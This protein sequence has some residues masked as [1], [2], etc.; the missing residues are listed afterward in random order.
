MTTGRLAALGAPCGGISRSGD[1]S[2]GIGPRH[3]GD[4]LRPTSLTNPTDPLIQ[5]LGVTNPLPRIDIEQVKMTATFGGRIEVDGAAFLT[6][7]NLTGFDDGAQLRRA[8]VSM[9]GDCILLLPV[10]YL[11][12]LGYRANQF[13][14]DEAYLFSPHISY[15][16]SLQFGFFSPPMGLEFITSSRDITFMEPPAPLQAMGPPKESGVQIGQPVFNRRRR[17]PSAYSAMRPPTPNTATLRATTA[18]PSVA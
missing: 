17:G 2:P 8:L 7:G 16:G 3:Q 5:F 1:V 12:Q 18:A 9:Q 13:Y 4:F 11:V 14:L 10:S 6:S 15:I